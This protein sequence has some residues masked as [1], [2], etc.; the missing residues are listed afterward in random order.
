MRVAVFN[1]P[2]PSSGF[3]STRFEGVVTHQLDS[4][5][6]LTLRTSSGGDQSQTAVWIRP[7]SKHTDVILS[8]AQPNN[9]VL[10]VFRLSTK[11]LKEWLAQEEAQT[12]VH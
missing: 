2:D 12:L 1:A 4:S 9:G 10:T 5:W 11:R 6:H 7:G 8:V 3:S